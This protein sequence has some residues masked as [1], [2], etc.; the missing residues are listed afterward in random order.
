MDDNYAKIHST[1][2]NYLSKIKLQ[3]VFLPFIDDIELNNEILYPMII[4]TFGITQFFWLM[5]VFNY[6]TLYFIY[7]FYL[8]LKTPLS[9]EPILILR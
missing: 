1:I 3:L 2:F 9:V 6:R 8:T 7:E 5:N 4:N